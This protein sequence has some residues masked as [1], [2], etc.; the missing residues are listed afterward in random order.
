VGGGPARSEATAAQREH[1]APH[2]RENGAVVGAQLSGVPRRLRTSGDARHNQHGHSVEVV[3]KMQS[4]LI[5]PASG[6]ILRRL[7]AGESARAVQ[8]RPVHIRNRHALR[9]VRD[10]H[11][12][13]PRPSGGKRCLH[14]EPEAIGDRTEVHGPLKIEASTDRAR[15]REEFVGRQPQRLSRP[16]GCQPTQARPA[17]ATPCRPRRPTCTPVRR[18]W[19]D[20]QCTAPNSARTRSRA[21]GTGAR[22][23]P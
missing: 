8:R 10:H 22:A 6:A 18:R 12:P 19:P 2:G 16:A 4:S 23:H 21:R 15:R 20:R 1:E 5:E 17:R 7:G 13:R 3:G 11:P 9:S 14:G